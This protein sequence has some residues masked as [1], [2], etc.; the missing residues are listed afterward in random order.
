MTPSEI[1]GGA[2]MGILVIAALSLIVAPDSQ[3]AKVISAFGSN[4]ASVIGA[5]KNY[6]K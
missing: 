2:V 1:V 5:A 4:F 6:P 3:A